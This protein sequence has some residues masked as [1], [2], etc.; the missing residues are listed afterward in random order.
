MQALESKPVSKAIRVCGCAFVSAG[1][2]GVSVYSGKR[3]ERM[4]ESSATVA[5]WTPA[6]R[7]LDRV[8]R[9]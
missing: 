1:S 4:D 5:V 3:G 6:F 8:F 7:F 9:L 2:G